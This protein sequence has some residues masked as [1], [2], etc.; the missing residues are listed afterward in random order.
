MKSSLSTL[1]E[2]HERFR[3][4]VAQLLQAADAVGYVP[5]AELRALL[6]YSCTFL[7]DHLLPHARAEETSLYQE[8]GHILGSQEA[9]LTM[10]HDHLAIAQLAG[11]LATLRSEVSGE[12]LSMDQARAIRRVLYGLHT[13]IS[14]HFEKEEGIYL[15]LLERNLTRGEA[16]RVCAA[17]HTAALVT[18]R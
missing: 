17:L 9:T 11:E 12:V 6:D 16:R 14:A 15:P 2:E 7:T 10:C 13:L 1:R 5:V 3:P 4:Q 18:R 8:V